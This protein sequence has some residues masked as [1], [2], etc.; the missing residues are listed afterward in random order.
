VTTCLNGE[1]IAKKIGE[2]FPEAVTDF[3]ES[4]VVVDSQ[5]LYKVAEYL[6][7]TDAYAFDYLVNLTSID[8][9]DYFELVYNLVSI[10]HNHS[11]VIKTRTYDRE[12]PVVPSVVSLWR[13]A[14]Y[15]EREIYD[16]M[17]IAFDGH[18]NLKR[19]FMWEGFP[20]HPLRRDYL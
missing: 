16:L 11:L 18:P 10:K 14:D 9:V 8:Y 15:Q 12:E 19:L 17:G 2:V 7:N 4:T 1:E 5:H 20:G 13:T 3:A 6:K